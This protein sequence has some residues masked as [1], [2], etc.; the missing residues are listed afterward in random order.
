MPS[1]RRGVEPPADVVDLAR[2]GARIDCDEGKARLSASALV[3]PFPEQVTA[4]VPCRMNE[5]DTAV[6]LL[7]GQL[8]GHRQQRRDPDAGA[9]QNDRSRRIT[10]QDE[11]P[12][13]P[14]AQNLVARIDRLVEECRNAAAAYASD[15]DAQGSRVRRR[16]NRVAAT[17]RHRPL[18]MRQRDRH[19]LA[20]RGRTN[21]S[22]VVRLEDEGDDVGALA[23]PRNADEA[24]P[25]AP[26][27][28]MAVAPDAR[29]VE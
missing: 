12:S 11:L 22:R 20:G 9:D 5:P 3:E 16:R 29:A 23:L 13:R 17:A 18:V 26:G 10:V 27:N 6:R 15:G 25:S 4:S 19:V 7:A 24:A 28:G 14:A 1:K 21:R 2:T 8:P